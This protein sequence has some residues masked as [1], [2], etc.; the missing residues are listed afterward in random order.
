MEKSIQTS[1]LETFQHLHTHAEISWEEIETTTYIKARLE[2]A[3]CET[4]TFSEHTGVVGKF[5]NFDKGLPVIGIRADMDALWQ[6]VNGTFQPNHSCGHDA[7]MSMVLGVLWS[8]Q[9]IPDMQDNVAI[10]F[11]Y[12]PAEEEGGGALKMVEEGVVEDVDYLFGIHLRPKQEVAAGKAAPVIVHGATKTYEAVI[13]G[14]DAHGARPHLNDNA[15]EIGMQIV[16]MLGQMHM[17]PRVPHS[18]KM[19]K[20]QAGAKSSNIIPGN[21]S[22][23]LDL[24][25]QSNEVME[26]LVKKVDAILE[27][28]RNLYDVDIDVTDYHGVP[29]AETNEEATNFMRTAVQ[30]VLGAGNV[31]ESL[32]TPG[33]DDFH[34]YTVKKPELKATM[35]G[36][37]CDLG[38]GLHHP[39][40]T[41]DKD[42][43]CTGVDI[44]TKA[45][46]NVYQV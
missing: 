24:R 25:A 23:S 7:H 3:G 4:I 34:F 1:M 17:D 36:L 39:N 32:L 43:L 26:V 46:L 33:G 18:A 9:Q 16:N 2:E 30:D 20:F 42:A 8:L 11:I 19:T 12:Q 22:F 28:V 38:P 13:K 41:F 5:G 29:A 14:E 35:L 27:S 44:L 21:A 31:V 40:M 45:I 6:E 37:G 10:K 15:I